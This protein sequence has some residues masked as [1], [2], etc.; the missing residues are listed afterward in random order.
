MT[1]V[2]IPRVRDVAIDDEYEIDC[3]WKY[4]YLSTSI[5]AKPS[6]LIN[7]SANQA[8]RVN[9]E[10]VEREKLAKLLAQ[11]DDGYMEAYPSAFEGLGYA[12]DEDDEGD[13]LTKVDTRQNFKRHEFES[14]EAWAEHESQREAIPKA[15][16]QFG[17]KKKDGRDTKQF[18][19][20]KLK[21]Q[22]RQVEDMIEQKQGRKISGFENIPEKKQRR[23]RYSEPQEPQVDM[24]SYEMR[25]VFIGLWC[26]TLN[27]F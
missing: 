20:Q 2:F 15:A 1:G 17:L 13:D 22:L 19:E 21:K 6:F 16:F 7:R 26:L 23:E 27:P 14:D 5:D 4:I 8:S 12:M 11:E 10:E 24:N 9:Q 25:Y 18:S 3:V